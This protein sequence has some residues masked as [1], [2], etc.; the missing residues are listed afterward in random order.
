LNGGPY[1]GFF[2]VFLQLTSELVREQFDGLE[3]EE[4]P[5]REKICK[6]ETLSSFRLTLNH[7]AGSSSF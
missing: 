3:K 7:H 6:E 1:L 2:R 4:N 5:F